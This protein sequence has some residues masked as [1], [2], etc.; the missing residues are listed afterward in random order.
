MK[1]EDDVAL[2]VLLTVFVL[3][4]TPK[5]FQRFVIKFFEGFL[6]PVYELLKG[7]SKHPPITD[8]SMIMLQRLRHDFVS[9]TW[10]L[11]RE[12]DLEGENEEEEP[13]EDDDVSLDTD[14]QEF[15][16]EDVMAIQQQPTSLINI[17]VVVRPVSDRSVRKN[18]SMSDFLMVFTPK[19][20]EMRFL[21]A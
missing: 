19:D 18:L 5:F 15:I 8:L 10:L 17:H 3:D 7:E 4:K 20:G 21:D 2:S 13:E 16:V 1:D 9:T 14:P 12:Y 6:V 11:R